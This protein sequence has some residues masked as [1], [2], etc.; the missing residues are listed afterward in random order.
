M[1][2]YERED[3]RSEGIT[4]HSFAGFALNKCKT[5]KTRNCFG[6]LSRCLC[7]FICIYLHGNEMFSLPFLFA[8]K[9]DR[10]ELL[11]REKKVG[12]SCGISSSKIWRNIC[13]KCR[14]N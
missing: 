9:G 7:T 14:E 12:N 3:R 10:T 6:E 2:N 8:K 5:V 1:K 4:H 13:R 11:R